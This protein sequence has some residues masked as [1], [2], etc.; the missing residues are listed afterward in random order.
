MPR[1]TIVGVLAVIL[2]IVYYA[3]LP[4]GAVGSTPQLTATV[5]PRRINLPLV[6]KQPTR[7]PTPRPGQPALDPAIW[8][9]V[10]A[11]GALLVYS[12]RV[13]NIGSTSDTFKLEVLPVPGEPP[14]GYV[15]YAL[16][17]PQVTV[18]PGSFRLVEV[19]AFI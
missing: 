7:T 2:T 10:G 19:A 3:S 8:E 14:T 16:N 1:R 11:P 4:Y 9:R 15:R 5:T 6:L 12:F 13:I 18:S 17:V